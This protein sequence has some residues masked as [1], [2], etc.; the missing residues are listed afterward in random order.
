MIPFPKKKYKVIY[1][2][3]PWYFQSY[4]KKGEGRNATKHYPCMGMDDIFNLPVSSIAD[5]DCFLFMWV[6]DPF[7]EKG[8]E[9]IKRWSFTYKTV[10]FTWVKGKKDQYLD[11]NFP[12]GLGYY[13]RANPEMCLLATKGKPKRKAKDIMQ[14]VLS[15]RKNHSSKPSMVRQRIDALC[16][17]VPKIELFAREK[18]P[19]TNWDFWGNEV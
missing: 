11:Y 14:L 3:P 15:P 9:V 17:N 13:T 4:S 12:M 10:G 7:L 16:G 19:L 2:D 1:A 5:N 18:P 6:T 8:L